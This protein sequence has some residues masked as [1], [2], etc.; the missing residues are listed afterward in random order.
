MAKDGAFILAAPASGSGKTTI[1]L[2]LL[3][4]FRNQA[5]NIRSFKIGPDYIDPAFHAAASG[6][7][8]PNIDGWAMAPERQR[9]IFHNQAEQA[10][11]V[12][13]EGVM[14][15]FDGARDG[16]GSTADLAATLTLPVILIVDAKGQSHSVAALIQGFAD[17]RNDIEIAGVI[18]NNVGSD[19]HRQML[20]SAVDGINM[21]AFGFVPRHDALVLAERHLGLV[22]AGERSDLEKF[23]DQAA[24]IVGQNTDIDALK[25]AVSRG[26]PA[27]PDQTGAL[28]MLGQHTAIA[29][30]AAFSFIYPHMLD[31]WRRAGGSVSFFSPLANE[32]PSADAD[33]LYLPGGYPELHARQL[34]GNHVFMNGLRTAA[35]AGKPIYGECGGYMTLGQSLTTRDGETVPMA[36]LLPVETSFAAP[37]RHLGYRRARLERD[38]P[39]GQKGAGFSAHEFHYCSTINAAG[40]ALFTATDAA[41]NDLGACGAVNGP[42][43]GSFLHLIDRAA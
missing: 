32:A 11:L 27:Y 7:P 13:G 25:A 9:A 29:R 14:G 2:A 17:F 35:A 18:F 30:D 34:A 23:L 22:Q 5:T 12:I 40:Q 43:M 38:G 26:M 42:V 4:Y 21:P 31:D 8:C 39:L 24:A 15:L 28:P 33:A 41:G 19:I 6:H 20:R 36:G 1:T 37:K 16:S 3:R 10:D